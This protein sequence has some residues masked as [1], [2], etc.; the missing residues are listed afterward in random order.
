MINEKHRELADNIVEQLKTST[1]VDESGLRLIGGEIYD[2]MRWLKEYEIISQTEVGQ[3]FVKGKYFMTYTTLDNL[4]NPS[5]EIPTVNLME[6]KSSK[7]ETTYKY[8][9]I[10]TAIGMFFFAGLTFSRETNYNKIQRISDTLQADKS[11][12]MG[13]IRFLQNSLEEQK[14]ENLQLLQRIDSLTK[15]V[16]R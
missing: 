15:K 5:K 9:M 14:G 2:V 1:S 3:P 16:N 11:K 10:F 6:Q 4:L 13:Q 8:V 12:L 7:L